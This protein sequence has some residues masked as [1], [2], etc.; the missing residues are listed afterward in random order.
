MS[1]SKYLVKS[2]KS[3]SRKFSWP[4]SIY[5][6]FKKGQKSISEVGKKFKAAKNAISQKKIDLFDFMR[7]F[8]GLFKFSAH[9]FQ[10]LS[11][12]KKTHVCIICWLVGFYQNW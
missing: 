12:L 11:K 7:F 9:C 8:P 5:C 2:N 10:R 3:I 6:N 4:N 1:R